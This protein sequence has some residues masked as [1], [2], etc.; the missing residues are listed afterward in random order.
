MPLRFHRSIRVV[1]GIK[2]NLGK[3]STSLSIG[4]RG[5]HVTLRPGHTA[6]TTVG[7]PGS[8]IRYTT[9]GQAAAK[10][11]QAHSK[12]AQS[13]RPSAPVEPTADE[14]LPTGRAWK[15]VLWLAIVILIATLLIWL[16]W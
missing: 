11:H 16:P 1:P 12:P 5:A 10:P 9:G 13:V 8:G 14:P 2:I 3:R 6:R 7:I 4:G 15:G